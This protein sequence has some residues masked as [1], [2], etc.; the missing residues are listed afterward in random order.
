MVLNVKK[1]SVILLLL[2]SSSLFSQ[3]NDLVKVSGFIF[4]KDSTTAIPYVYVVNK[5]TLTGTASDY[6]GSFEIVGGL[7]DTLQI[8][9]VGYEPQKISISNKTTKLLII[10]KPKAIAL[11]TI[12]VFNKS[13]NKAEKEYYQTKV[14]YYKKYS[15]DISS[16][17]TALYY[18]FSKEGRQLKK[19]EPLIADLEYKEW[20]EKRLPNE[21]LYSLTNNYQLDADGFRAFLNLNPEEINS[22]TDYQLYAFIRAK[23]RQYKLLK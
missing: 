14:D 6:N 16:P 13:F 22:I 18:Q 23:Y 3:K 17:I 5:S 11:Q 7:G 21:I 2:V 8:S 20:I 1:I 19:L 4:E 12:S 9:C 15:K 10:L